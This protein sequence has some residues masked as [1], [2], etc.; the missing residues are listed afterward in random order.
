MLKKIAVLAI[1][2]I[3]LMLSPMNHGD[4]VNADNEWLLLDTGINVEGGII[5]VSIRAD[6]GKGLDS[7]EEQCTIPKPSEVCLSLTAYWPFDEQGNPQPWNGQADATPTQT[8]NGYHITVDDRNKVAAAPLPLI[9][10]NVDALGIEATIQ[11]T[12]G[13]EVYQHG[14]FW[15][16]GYERWVL[17]IDILSDEPIHYLV[18][19]D[20]EVTTSKIRFDGSLDALKTQVK[21]GADYG[22][23]KKI[24]SEHSAKLKDIR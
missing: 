12:F 13:H 18:C 11:D 17:P 20:F 5:P 22:Q 15:H 7:D 16:D 1:V 2:T 9:G 3:V 23:S 4:I 21:Q 14:A 8:A 19:D 10:G 6:C 24:S